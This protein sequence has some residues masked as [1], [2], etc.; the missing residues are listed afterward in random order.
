MAGAFV[1]AL[2]SSSPAKAVDLEASMNCWDPHTD[3]LGICGA[4]APDVILGVNT[5]LSANLNGCGIF[6]GGCGSVGSSNFQ[7][8]FKPNGPNNVGST[9]VVNTNATSGNITTTFQYTATG[10]YRPESRICNS[11]GANCSDWDKWDVAL[12]EYDLDVGNNTPPSADM[13]AWSPCFASCIVG[14]SPDGVPQ[15]FTLSA[16]YNDSDN[17][18]GSRIVSVQWD[19]DGNSTVDQTDTFGPLNS[20]SGTRTTLHYYTE[21][22]YQPQVRF[23][24][25]NGC[26]GWDKFDIIGINTD[27]DVVDDPP[28]VTMEWWSPCYQ[29]LGSCAG[30]SPDGRS[31][32]NF[33]LN[34]SGSDDV[35]V[36]NYEWDF[37]GN[38]TVDQTTGGGGTGSVVHNYN[39]IGTWQPQVRAVDISGQRSGWDK[40]DI[41]LVNID[42]DTDGPSISVNMPNPCFGIYPACIGGSPDAT[43]ADVVQLSADYSDAFGVSVASVQWDFDGNGSVD[44]TTSV[45]GTSGTAS[46]THQYGS[47]GAYVIKARAVGSDGAPGTWQPWKIL[48]IQADYDVSA[49][50]V[51]AQMQ[52]PDPH[53]STLGIDC[54]GAPD[55]RVNNNVLLKADIDTC[56]SLCVGNYFTPTN[57][58]DYDI[59]WRLGDASP[60]VIQSISGGADRTLN[61]PSGYAVAGAYRPEV[62]L[63]DDAASSTNCT[64]WDRYD[65]ALVEYDYDADG[66]TTSVNMPNPCFGIYPACIG[67]SPDA[68]T[69]DVVQLSADYTDAFGVNVANVEWDFDGNGSVDATSSASGTSGTVN[70][71]HQYSTPGVYQ[72]KA[73]AIGTDGAVGSWDQWDILGIAADYDV[74]ATQV[75]AQMQC[76][77]PHTSTLGIDCAGAPDVRVNSSVLLKSDIDTCSI[78]CVGNYFTPTDINDFD[79]EWRLGDGSPSVIDSISGGADRTHNFPSGY[80]VAG[81]YRPEVRLCDDAA[82]STNCSSWDRYDV[83]LVEY[84]Y[85]AEGPSATVD[86]PD[87]CFGIYPAC[88]GG[89]PDATTA[90]TVTMNMSYTD[91]FGVAVDHIEWDFDGDG[92]VDATS[93]ASG[94]SGTAQTTHQYTTAGTYTIKAR[95]VGVDGAIGLWDDWSILGISTDYDVGAVQVRAQMAC[96]DPHDATVFICGAGP[97]DVRVNNPTTLNADIDTCGLGILCVGNYFTPTDQNDFD[98]EW[99]LN[100]PAGVTS[101]IDNINASGATRSHVFPAGYNTTGAYRPEVR[102]CDDAATS[103]NCTSWDKYDVVLVEYDLDVWAPCTGDADHDGIPCYFDPDGDTS[104]YNHQLNYVRQASAPGIILTN[105]D[106]D[107]AIIAPL[108]MNRTNFFGNWIYTGQMNFI[109]ADIINPTGTYLNLKWSHFGLWATPGAGS[110][111]DTA[112]LKGLSFCM[113]AKPGSLFGYAFGFCTY[114]ASF[115]DDQQLLEVEDEVLFSS[116]IPGYGP[117]DYEGFTLPLI[118]PEI[119]VSVNP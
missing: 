102:L 97:K 24:D 78:L 95:A 112:F 113:G 56:A 13:N 116:Y 94:T 59:E 37:D 50:Q 68:N 88:I 83:A 49:A 43:T 98:I 101:A 110:S 46:T 17:G 67:G 28:S 48:G 118:S 10:A 36:T 14:G 84:D 93:A 12:V 92:T 3:T 15:N 38:G 76:P 64:S 41:V 11:S 79:I 114:L 89:A 16:D 18:Q 9:I 62:R 111:P 26:G 70:T 66:P 60:S 39:T 115:D 8:Q 119:E 108:N 75:R 4:G 54:A 1:V 5:T 81:A 57:I 52:C 51:R 42:L 104:T 87:P 19:F 45:S 82:T 25:N 32:Q 20:A 58:N 65:V 30:G 72:I 7:V 35:G 27:L 109:Q 53:T 47:P 96:W 71:T 74:A 34:A 103:T 2:V 69:G 22:V 31:N 44:D 23:C 55:V 29:I 91:D 100:G 33:T 61:F 21:G 90:D 105:S 63:C 99:R 117:T 77:D 80:A 85:D 73:R 6:D 40:K 86:N 106:P 107:A